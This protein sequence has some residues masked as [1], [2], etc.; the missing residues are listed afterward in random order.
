MHHVRS[1]TVALFFCV[2]AASHASI[3]EAWQGFSAPEILSDGFTHSYFTLPAEG[4]TSYNGPKFW[5]SDYWPSQAGG[6]N[7]RWAAPRPSGFHTYDFP[8]NE[9]M[10][11][12][13]QQ[14]KALSPSEKYD[15]YMGRYDYPLKAEVAGRVSPTAADWEGICHGWVVAALHHA[16]PQPK[17]LMNRDGVSV[18]FGSADIKGLLS[19]YYAW[20]ADNGSETVGKRCTFGQWTGGEAACDQDLNAGAFHIIMT[21]RIG[22][23][24]EGIIMDVERWDQVWNQPVIAYR[25]QV[26]GEFRPSQT[27]ARGT[28]RELRLST[29]VW[30]VNE[31]DNLWNPVHGTQNQKNDS[32]VFQYRVELN[33]RDEIIGGTWE[34]DERPDFI[35]QKA[36]VE[37]FSGYFANINDLLND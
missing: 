15:I 22:L 23:Q 18:P 33:A 35:W 4:A 13:V 36:K 7:N 2:S 24:G 37:T 34:S 16:E 1:L 32:K 11:M 26:M 30:Y 29:Q 20:H 27:A 6:I 5:S 9:V 31:T 14:M 3:L 21:N 8:R 28:V 12:S 10:R 25:A 17:V 19:F